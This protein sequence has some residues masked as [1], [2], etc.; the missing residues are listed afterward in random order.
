MTDPKRISPQE[1][2]VKL[3]EGWTYDAYGEF[4]QTRSLDFHNNDTSNINMQNAL[5]AVKD[6]L[7]GQIVCRGGNP[8]CVPWNIWNPATPP[9][10]ASLAYISAPG[11]YSAESSEDV[12]SGYISGDL[13]SR[14]IKTPW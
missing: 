12:I 5:L 13:T 11:L 14:G 1:A 10:A 8:G 6:P 2:S 9:S 7:T 4:S 3:A